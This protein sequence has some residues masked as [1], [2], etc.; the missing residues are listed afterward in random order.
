LNDEQLDGLGYRLM[1]LDK[2]LSGERL[3]ILPGGSNEA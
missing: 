3:S 1:L 2:Q